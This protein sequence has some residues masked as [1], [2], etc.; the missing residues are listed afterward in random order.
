MPGGKKT[1]IKLNEIS[2]NDI[3]TIVDRNPCICPSKKTL[4]EE[5]Y[6]YVCQG[7][8]PLTV[9]EL[10]NFL[11]G[12]KKIS[13]KFQV[14]GILT[15]IRTFVQIPLAKCLRIWIKI[16]QVKLGNY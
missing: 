16:F 4:K 10:I 5:P 15:K 9:I 3:K 1:C 11:K 6:D 8:G 12:K 2:S 13:K 14:Y 7:E